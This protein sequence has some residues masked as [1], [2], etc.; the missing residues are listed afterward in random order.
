MEQVDRCVTG[1]VAQQQTVGPLQLPLADVAVLAQVFTSTTAITCTCACGLGV[2]RLFVC[3]GFLKPG[4]LL[5]FNI[6]F[7]LGLSFGILSTDTHR[8]YGW[9]MCDR[10]ATH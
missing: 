2:Y 4:D 8:N 5:S 6:K 7:P 10:R 9:C 1:L 3:L